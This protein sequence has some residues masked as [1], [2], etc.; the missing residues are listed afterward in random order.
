MVLYQD[1]DTR[2]DR[3]VAHILIWNPPC[4]CLM[5]DVAVPC[6]A[7][8]ALL[9]PRKR[10]RPLAMLP[11]VL[12]PAS[13]VGQTAAPEQLPSTPESAD[14]P[15]PFGPRCLDRSATPRYTK[16][17]LNMSLQSRRPRPHGKD[18]QSPYKLAPAAR[19]SLQARF[20]I[21]QDATNQT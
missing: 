1:R 16:H 20:Q 2:V 9:V 19:A 8:R 12:H 6:S 7:L 18:V 14:G 11:H 17:V 5:S 15:H 13:R 10:L 4:C 21:L 3:P